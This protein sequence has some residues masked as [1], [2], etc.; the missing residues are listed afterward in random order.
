MKSEDG[1]HLKKNFTTI[2]M[3]ANTRYMRT[4]FL[5]ASIPHF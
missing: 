1:T 4:A 3:L 5:C 2:T